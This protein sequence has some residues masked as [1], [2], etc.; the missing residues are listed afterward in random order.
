MVFLCISDNISKKGLCKPFSPDGREYSFGNFDK[1]PKRIGR[2][3]G[4]MFADKANSFASCY[5]Y[6]H[7]LSKKNSSGRRVCMI[8]S[9]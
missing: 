8:I 9:W 4:T 5:L 6:I 3:A 7:F 2:T 1:V